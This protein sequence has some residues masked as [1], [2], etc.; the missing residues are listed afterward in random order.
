MR[1]LGLTRRTGSRWE[2]HSAALRVLAHPDALAIM[3]LTIMTGLNPEGSDSI[4]LAFPAVSWLW[5]GGYVAS[6]LIV[7]VGLLA[8]RT[9]MEAFGR[10]LFC[11]ALAVRILAV[12]QVEGWGETI[13][14]ALFLVASAIRAYLL[15]TSRNTFIAKN[16]FPGN[17][18]GDDAVSVPAVRPPGADVGRDVSPVDDDERGTP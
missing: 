14:Y 12:I 6:G 10:L 9:D 1:R 16:V 15:L 4:N 17:D 13:I 18:L 5:S 8:S 3:V 11:G 7:I 2:A